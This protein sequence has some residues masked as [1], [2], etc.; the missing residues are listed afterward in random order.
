MGEKIKILLTGMCL[1]GNKGGPALVLSL[2]NKLSEAGID[3]DFT[4]SVPSGLEFAHEKRWGEY[5]GLTVAEDFLTKEVLP[6]YCFRKTS[7]AQF[8]HRMKKAARWIK[9][10]RKSDIIIDSSGISYYGPPAGKQRGVLLGNRL[11]YF[12]L[13]KIFRRSFLA[14]TQSYGPFSTKAIAFAA[15]ADLSRQPVVFCRGDDSL[16]EVKRILPE[17]KCMSFPDVAL[18]LAYEKPAETDRPFISVS[19]SS[20]IYTKIGEKHIENVL[21]ITEYALNKGYEVMLVPHTVRPGNGNP[22]LC[23]LSL[24][25]LIKERTDDPRVTLMDEDLP[26]SAIKSVVA[27]SHIHIGARYH[28]IVAALSSGVPAISLSWHYKYVDLMRNYGMEGCVHDEVNAQDVE[29]VFEMIDSIEE[30]YPGLK[31][32]LAVKQ[33]EVSALIDENIRI[34]AGLIKERCHGGR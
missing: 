25:R 2:I 7:F 1:Q 22:K 28:S 18:S 5:Y 17:Q 34:F 11:R 6:P 20:V 24:A 19:P 23:D 33:A 16:E 15:K 26:P 10:L 14:W 3:A 27:A 21:K 4:I 30:N 8:R 13:S 32:T 9:V 29:P 31:E 12:V